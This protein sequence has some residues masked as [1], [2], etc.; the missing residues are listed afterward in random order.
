[1]SLLKLYWYV[2]I[3][4]LIFVTSI[5]LT[6]KL[7]GI[8]FRK[9]FNALKLM[10]K[11][12]K[13][14]NGEISSFG[15]LCVSLSATIGTGSIIGV[16]VAIKIGGPGTLLWMII[17]SI[18]SLSIKYSEG[19]LAIKYRKIENDFVIGGPFSYI[20]YGMGKKYRFLSKSYAL[21]GLLAATLG[22]G[23][24]TQ[25]NGITDAF[26]NTFISSCNTWTNLKISILIGAVIAIISGLVIFGGTKRITR[27]CESVIPL[28]TVIYIFSILL[29]IFN[30]ISLLSSSVELI[31]KSAF[32]IKSFTI[33]TTNYLFIT[34]I[35]QGSQKGVFINEAGLGSSAIALSCSKEKDPETQG[36]ISMGA[37]LV[38]TFISI[39]TGIVIVLMS[40]YTKDLS[41]INITNDAFINGLSFNPIISSLILFICILFFAITTIIGWS[42]YGLKCL[43]YLFNKNKKLEK[44]YLM[45]Y[46]IMVFLGAIIKVDFIWNIADV[47]NALMAIP[48]LIALIYLSDIVSMETN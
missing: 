10:L 35:V 12:N 40:S 38:T 17:F 18:L 47:C 45:I 9:I 7:K 1:M 21:F 23:T 41:G 32:N 16:A 31:I 2:P 26:R 4:I 5:L 15:A 20:E 43:N 39:L 46:I 30:N 3:L 33:G 11:S 34:M 19:F 44:N 25:S 13:E 24:M 37:M 29:I 22:I 48:N 14:G 28:V 27:I 6:I 42:L 36:L 8:Q